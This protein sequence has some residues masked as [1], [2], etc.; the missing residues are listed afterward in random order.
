VPVTRQAAYV[1]SSRARRGALLRMLAVADG[2]GLP[3]ETT[4]LQLSLDRDTFGTLLAGLER[5]GLL[6]RSGARL[7]LGGAPTI[8]R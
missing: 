1:G 8:R 5:D 2:N 4:R 7:C 6:Y 3:A